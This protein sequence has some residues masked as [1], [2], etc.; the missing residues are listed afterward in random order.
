MIRER[1]LDRLVG[2]N[3]P[4]L[5]H[6]DIVDSQQWPECGKGGSETPPCLDET[7]LVHTAYAMVGVGHRVVVEVSAHYSGAG[8]VVEMVEHRIHLLRPAAEGLAVFVAGLVHSRSVACESL[9][10]IAQGNGIGLEMAVI[11]SEPLSAGLKFGPKGEIPAVFKTDFAFFRGFMSATGHI[12]AEP[13]AALEQIV[14][15]VVARK[16][17]PYQMPYVA[18]VGAGKF[19]QTDHVGIVAGKESED[20][21]YSLLTVFN[22]PVIGETVYVAGDYAYAIVR[23]EHLH[24]VLSGPEETPHKEEGWQDGDKGN[25]CKSG[26]VAGRPDCEYDVDYENGQEEQTENGEEPH[27]CR[28]YDSTQVGQQLQPRK[29]QSHNGIGYSLYP[30]EQPVLFL[31]LLFSA[32]HINTGCTFSGPCARS[33]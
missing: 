15:N 20:G 26:F 6:K 11:H 2:N 18:G 3:R 10:D 31:L 19:L 29:Y 9:P 27:L 17:F 14:L 22:F 23:I 4:A 8:A 28:I 7:V 1:S 16:F 5:R 30:M 21:I 25:E 12:S 32:G 13:L 24:I 33:E